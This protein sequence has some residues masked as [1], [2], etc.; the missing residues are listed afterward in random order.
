MGLFVIAC[1]RPKPGKYEG[2]LTVLKKH[3]PILRKED[4]ITDMDAILM[5]TKE[6][7]IIEIFE[8]KSA[9]A[10]KAA[11]ENPSVRTLWSEFEE[12]S[13]Y[14]SLNKLEENS[15]FFPNFRRLEIN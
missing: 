9:E 8:W 13:E 14:I 7:N 5:E 15:E 3:M 10:I 1:F 12:V 4:L 11:H 2:L 6:G